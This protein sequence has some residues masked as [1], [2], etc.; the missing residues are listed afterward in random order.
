MRSQW[1]EEGMEGL[2][3]TDS[4]LLP[5]LGASYGLCHIYDNSLRWK[6][7][8]YVFVSV[9]VLHQQGVYLRKIQ[10]TSFLLQRR[11]EKSAFRTFCLPCKG[12]RCNTMCKMH[13]I[14]ADKS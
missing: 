10:H 5:G 9:C 7:I 14:F 12:E 1:L 11:R 6:C 8:I 3:G 4:V 2:L 13:G